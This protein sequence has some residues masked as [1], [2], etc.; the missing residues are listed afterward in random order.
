V[1]ISHCSNVF[2]EGQHPEKFIPR[3]IYEISRG[4][5]VTIHAKEDG[6]PGSRM[7][8]HTE[9]VTAAI[10]IL[11]EQG[12]IHGKYNIPGRKYSN[13]EI[14]MKISELLGKPL[15]YKLAYPYAERPGW[16]FSYDINGAEHLEALGWERGNFK[17]QLLQTI[18]GEL[19]R[20]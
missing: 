12:K 2:G 1:V 16:D 19:C 4:R 3:L 17:A 5:E 7:Y 10:R 15:K 18:Q 8:I 11:L 13:L 9:D 20:V 6:E 14:A